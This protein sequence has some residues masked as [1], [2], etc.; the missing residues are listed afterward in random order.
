MRRRDARK[1]IKTE[2]LRKEQNGRKQEEG[3]QQREHGES[4]ARMEEDA[5]SSSSSGSGDVAPTQSS[6]SSGSATKMSGHEGRD[7]CT[8]GCCEGSET[9]ED[10]P[11][12]R[13]PTARHQG[14]DGEDG[15]KMRPHRVP[16]AVEARRW[17]VVRMV[18]PEARKAAVEH[19][20]DPERE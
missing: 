1:S 6:S 7:G 14:T 10:G 17:R 18:V 2:R 13:V 5:P 12:R 16:A 4:T 9:N 20:E 15:G 19:P 3:Q 11:G 8:E